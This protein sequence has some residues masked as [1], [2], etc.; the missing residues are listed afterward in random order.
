MKREFRGA[1]YNIEVENPNHVSKG[2]KSVVVN[3]HELKTNSIPILEKGKEH[4][5]KIIMG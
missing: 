2:V 5:V 1:F 3:G 4:F